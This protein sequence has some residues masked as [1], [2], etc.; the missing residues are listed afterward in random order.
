MPGLFALRLAY[1][2][3]D[4]LGLIAERSATTGALARL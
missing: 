3:E 4:R 2:A 1:D